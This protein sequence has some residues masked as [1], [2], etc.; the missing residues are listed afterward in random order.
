[1]STQAAA[2]GP[3][4]PQIGKYQPVARIAAGGMGA[5]YRGIDVENGRDV[6]LKVLSPEWQSKPVLLKRFQL[7]A[8]HGEQLDPHPNIVSFYEYGEVGGLHYLALEFVDGIDLKDFIADR[9]KCDVEESRIIILQAARALGHLHR[10]GITHRDIKPSNF[11]ISHGDGQPIVKLID[12]GLARNIDDDEEC[13]VTRHGTTLGTVDYIAPEQARDSSAADVRSDIY[14]LGCTWFHMLAGQP[15]FPEGTVT[16]RIVQHMEAVAPNIRKLNKAV[17]ARIGAILERMLAKDPA[18]RYQTP[19][20]LVRDLENI[21]RNGETRVTNQLLAGLA[22]GTELQEEP[23]AARKR[24]RSSG[25][26]ETLRVFKD[27]DLDAQA[28]RRKRS[29]RRSGLPSWAMPVIVAATCILVVGIGYLVHRGS[30][31]PAPVEEPKAEIAPPPSQPTLT[32]PEQTIAVPDAR[33]RRM[34]TPEMPPSFE[35]PPPPKL[36]PPPSEETAPPSKLPPPGG[37]SG[38]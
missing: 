37:D 25:S 2:I 7:E 5:V 23:R 30:R 9:G 17:P 15:P 29:R 1:M 36:P 21:S 35:Q 20:E 38:W 24:K 18:D 22:A 4:L 19:A 10:H 13:R 11:L 34:L 32:L 28:A 8:M 12:L 31:P 6:A 33:P 16:E 26:S 14:A 27:E 3:R